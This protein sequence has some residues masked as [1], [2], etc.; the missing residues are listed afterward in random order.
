L[1]LLKACE[2]FKEKTLFCYRISA[3]KN[4]KMLDLVSTVF[5]FLISVRELHNT[6]IDSGTL[7]TCEF[8][9]SLRQFYA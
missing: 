9:T 2:S 3:A 4:K 6:M 5:P 8:D 7:A 1:A